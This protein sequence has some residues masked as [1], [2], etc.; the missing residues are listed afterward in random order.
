MLAAAAWA[1]GQPPLQSLVIGFALSLSSTA[2]ILQ[3][4]AERN[5]LRDHHG[6][7]AFG[8]LLFQDIAVMPALALL[9]LA[10]GGSALDWRDVALGIAVLLGV[11]FGGRYVLRPLLRIVAQTRGAR[12]VHGRRAA[13]GGRH[14]AGVRCG[15]LVHGARRIHRR[16]AARRQRIPPRTRGGHRAV[17]GT[18]ARPVLHRR[19]H[20]RHI[21][22][23][24]EQ[25]FVV[26]GLVVGFLVLKGAIMWPVARLTAHRGA[27]GRRLAVTMAGGGEFAFVLFAIAAGDSVL[28]PAARTCW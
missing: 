16:R 2:L 5:E 21:S 11:S 22:L 17:Q 27:T 14:G 12:G 20:V 9:P 6:R 3:V 8:I 28:D 10:A 19:R 26:F 18:A 24:A 4:L 1:L 25:P 13:G 23:L 15:R 7:S